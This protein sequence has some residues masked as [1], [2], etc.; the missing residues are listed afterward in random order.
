MCSIAL[1]KVYIFEEVLVKKNEQIGVYMKNTW[2]IMLIF[3]L[4]SHYG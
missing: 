4:K 3:I 1:A 2:Y